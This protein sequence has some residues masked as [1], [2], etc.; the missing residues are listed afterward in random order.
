MESKATI[1]ISLLFFFGVIDLLGSKP[2]S[3]SFFASIIISFLSVLFISI[4]L[5]CLFELMEIFGICWDFN[6]LLF[7]SNK[8]DALLY[9]LKLIFFLACF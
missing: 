6:K 7:F 2:F 5:F 1:F 4:I 3:F 9:D 8:V